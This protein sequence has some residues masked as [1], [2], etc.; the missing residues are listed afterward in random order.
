MDR[1]EKEISTTNELF[2]EISVQVQCRVPESITDAIE[3]YNGEEEV[4][5]VL[6]SDAARKQCNAA[7][8]VLRDS[9]TE[10]DWAAVAQKAVD[11][12]EPGRRGGF[13]VTVDASEL[14]EVM[15]SG[16]VGEL[17]A[18]LQSKGANVDG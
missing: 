7:R 15:A 17:L 11:Q 9:E 13:G 1:I 2:G 3:F 12:Y 16:D 10:L 4:L 14:D 5:K 8:P 6:Q 18:Y